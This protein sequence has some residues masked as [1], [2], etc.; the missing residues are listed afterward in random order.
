MFCVWDFVLFEEAVLVFE[1]GYV[2]AELCILIIW[3]VQFGDF[4]NGVQV[5]IDQFIFFGEQKWG[6]MCG[7]VML[8]LYGYEGQGLEYFFV[9]L[10]RYL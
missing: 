7:L 5:V 2:T 3:E 4:V 6:W 9:C 10:E 8:L 1:Y